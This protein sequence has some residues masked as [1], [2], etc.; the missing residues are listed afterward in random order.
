MHAGSKLI[1]YTDFIL[2][3]PFI[4]E[5]LCENRDQPELKCG[6]KCQLMKSL[7]KDDE[8]KSDKQQNSKKIDIQLFSDE[9]FLSEFSK[10]E[11]EH[12]DGRKFNNHYQSIK[13]DGE[14]HS[15]FRPPIL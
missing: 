10:K 3:Q 6:G 12:E 9:Q 13:T 14:P 1:I 11:F 4:A 8:N 2:N 7:K 5:N 15:I